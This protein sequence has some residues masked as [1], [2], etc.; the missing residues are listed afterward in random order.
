MHGYANLTRLLRILSQEIVFFVWTDGY[1][2]SLRHLNYASVRFGVGVGTILLLADRPVAY[3]P[4]AR[5]VVAAEAN[6]FVTEQEL[7]ATVEALCILFQY[8]AHWSEYLQ[9][10]HLI[11]YTCLAAAM[12]QTL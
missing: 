4:I 8:Q 2:T 7:L 10:F 5:K 11:G 6:Y 3:Y 9:C 12:L 1:D